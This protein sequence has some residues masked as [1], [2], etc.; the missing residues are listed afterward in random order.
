MADAGKEVRPPEPPP[1]PPE[2][3]RQTEPRSDQAGAERGHESQSTAREQTDA[4]LKAEHASAVRAMHTEG[5]TIDPPSQQKGASDQQD[6]DGR[7]ATGEQPNTQARAH[8]MTDQTAA[9]ELAA[10]NEAPD[11]D[12]N[13]AARGH[14]AAT[15]SGAA[16][17]LGKAF[18]RAG[19]APDG[20][21]GEGVDT[22]AGDGVPPP[23]GGRA[24]TDVG[25]PA[26]T[27][28][29]VGRPR[30]DAR[31]PPPAPAD[32]TRR[33]EE[34]RAG[35]PDPVG[36]VPG[37]ATAAGRTDHNAQ[38][39][40]AGRDTQQQPVVEQDS[41]RQVA[42]EQGQT[43]DE[44]TRRQATAEQGPSEQASKQNRA[45]PP[46][47]ATE[48]AAPPGRDAR[49]EAEA[50][51]GGE[52]VGGPVA[53]ADEDPVLDVP[54]AEGGTGDLPDTE[55]DTEAND[56]RDAADR[57]RLQEH[58]YGLPDPPTLRTERGPDGLVDDIDGRPVKELVQ[59]LSQQRNDLYRQM[60]TDR[61]ELPDGRQV[62]EDFTERQTGAMHSVLFDRRTGGFFEADNRTVAYRQPTN[63][64]PTLQN[65]LNRMDD[66]ARQNPHHYDYGRGQRGGFPH[67][68]VPGTHSE[69]TAAN[70]AL[71]A[72]EAAGHPT[73]PDA[74]QELTVDNRRLFGGRAG[75][76]AACCA[77]C[78]SI[79]GDIV[80]IPGK[81]T[82]FP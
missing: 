61:T 49:T 43:A 7:A 63:L 53:P 31:Q 51:L 64:H 42:G 68:D 58:G 38:A 18:E 56:A 30:T 55:P 9:R 2:I 16:A 82:E 17:D 71:W 20:A 5:A 72:R 40:A 77:N 50:K 47:Q 13:G 15:E 29:E 22:P 10:A 59:D 11:G 23:T 32:T 75:S 79:L 25:S 1:K 34:T 76:Q 19:V 35:V 46:P 74:L 81:K 3:P 69:V 45:E 80:A 33:Q 41:Q 65:E 14:A 12:A 37:D 21:L 6:S 78:T 67:P 39:Q 28:E 24:I 36:A 26:V 48:E 57:P 70:Q 60:Q 62:R 66:F 27:T 44:G 73:G 52:G 4:A 54:A 8:A